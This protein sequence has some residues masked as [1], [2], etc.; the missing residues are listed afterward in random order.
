MEALNKNQ[1]VSPQ[2]TNNGPSE[3]TRLAVANTFEH[4]SSQP[5]FKDLQTLSM[6]ANPTPQ[7]IK[8]VSAGLLRLKG[9]A[10]VAGND[11]AT[12]YFD[13]YLKSLQNDYPQAFLEA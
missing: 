11:V 5:L 1:Q 4:F 7:D 12:N 10:Q 13:Q 3:S 6:Q 8:A 2:E 9:E